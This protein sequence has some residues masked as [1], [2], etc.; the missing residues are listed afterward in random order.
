[1]LLLLLYTL[2][3][4]RANNLAQKHYL[5]FLKTKIKFSNETFKLYYQILYSTTIL[6][7]FFKYPDRYFDHK[8]PD[9]EL[10]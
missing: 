7:Y 2:F 8:C 3:T 9:C 1:M 5:Y 4:K 6:L 10:N